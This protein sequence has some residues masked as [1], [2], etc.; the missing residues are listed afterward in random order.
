MNL[1]IRRFG[2]RFH[3][4]F[5]LVGILFFIY[6]APVVYVHFQRKP[7][8]GK[9]PVEDWHYAYILFEHSECFYVVP[10]GGGKGL[11]LDRLKRSDSSAYGD[12]VRL[13]WDGE[14]HHL[15]ILGKYYETENYVSPWKEMVERLR[16]KISRLIVYY[17]RR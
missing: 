6:L 17:L 11:P 7:L 14:R 2:R 16:G 10:S 8:Y 5:C 1:S 12:N 9:F 3:L 13:E 4:V 15:W